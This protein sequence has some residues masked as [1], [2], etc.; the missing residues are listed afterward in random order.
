MELLER[1]LDTFTIGL[2]SWTVIHLFVWLAFPVIFPYSYRVASKHTRIKFRPKSVAFVFSLVIV[3]Y[4]WPIVFSRDFEGMRKGDPLLSYDPYVH[5]VYALALSYFVYDFIVTLLNG[6]PVEFLAHAFLCMLI[7]WQTF[8]PF[9]TY[10]GAGLLL[11]EAST[12]FLHLRWFLLQLGWDRKSRLSRVN[13]LVFAVTFFVSRIIWGF[14]LCLEGFIYLQGFKER[15]GPV[16]FYF[17][18]IAGFLLNLLN[19]YWFTI[20]VRNALNL[21]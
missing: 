7:Y 15:V 18:H 9:M 14:Y 3:W 20:I 16:V 10:Y 12:P 5:G 4:A 2:A 11:F 17:T 1:H 6:D 21:K 13:S 8:T 19:L